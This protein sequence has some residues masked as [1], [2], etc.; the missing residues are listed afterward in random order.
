VQA[1]AAE[2]M[3]TPTRVYKNNTIAVEWRPELCVHCQRCITE[4]PQVFNLSARPW[5]DINGASDKE[6][7]QQVEACPTKALSMGA[8][9]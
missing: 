5:V 3:S 6:I 2:A 7:I 4:L 9:P 1:G 8:L